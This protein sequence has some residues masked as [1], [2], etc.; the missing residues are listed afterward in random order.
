MKLWYR[1]GA[2]NVLPVQ[3]IPVGEAVNGLNADL[4]ERPTKREGVG[5]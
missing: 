1:T 2:E 3:C 4:E 5:T